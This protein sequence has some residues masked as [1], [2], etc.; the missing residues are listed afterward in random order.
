MNPTNAPTPVTLSDGSVVIVSPLTSRDMTTIFNFVRQKELTRLL[1]AIPKDAEVE[2]RKMMI[3][4]AYEDS[5][6]FR[7]DDKAQFWVDPDVQ[8]QAFYISLVKETK[9]M[10]FEKIDSIMEV[11]EDQS[12]ILSAMNREPPE[13]VLEE[14][15]AN[16]EQKKTE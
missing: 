5:R 9:G 13:E 1:A 12:A 11:P 3:K 7:V 4:L 15:S 6:D 16:A 10:T 8:R 14:Q 2:T